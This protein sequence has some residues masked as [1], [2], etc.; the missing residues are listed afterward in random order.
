MY[1]YLCIYVYILC[2]YVYIVKIYIYI[3]Y[4]YTDK[5]QPKLDRIIWGSWGSAWMHW[6][7]C[8]GQGQPFVTATAKRPHLARATT[9]PHQ[10][11]EPLPYSPAASKGNHL[12]PLPS[13]PAASEGNHLP[14][15][16]CHDPYRSVLQRARGNHCHHH[17]QAALQRARTNTCRRQLPRSLAIQPCSEH[18]QPLATTSGHNHCRSGLQWAC[19]GQ[20]QPFVTTARQ[21]C[22]E[23]TNHF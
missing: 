12:P 11:P 1:R 10:L 16:L 5:G 13:S 15:S 23:Q 19:S 8:I 2:V 4:I 3:L 18:G 20:G 6:K 9:R 17:W 22:S 14:A 7:P 21:P